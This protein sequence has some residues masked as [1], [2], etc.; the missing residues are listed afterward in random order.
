MADA[1]STPKSSQDSKADLLWEATRRNEDYRKEYY[2]ALK[3]EKDL[4]PNRPKEILKK[5]IESLQDH[6]YPSDHI[7]Y[8]EIDLLT[9]QPEIIYRRILSDASFN[10]MPF[11]PKNRWKISMWDYSN[12]AKCYMEINQKMSEIQEQNMTSYLLDPSISS[13]DIAK[14]IEFFDNADLHPYQHRFTSLIYCKYPHP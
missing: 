8:K 6:N 7:I 1:I 9:K 10:L 5:L 11:E 14:E 13:D 4:F 2:D 3:K 12:F